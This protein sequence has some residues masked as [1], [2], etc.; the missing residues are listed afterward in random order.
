[1]KSERESPLDSE[2]G[3]F[4]EILR[5]SDTTEA[6]VI[7]G[8]HAAGFWSR[9]FLSRGVTELAEFLPFRSEDLKN[10]I[11]GPTHS[12]NSFPSE[13]P[14]HSASILNP[15][16]HNPQKTAFFGLA[17]ANPSASFRPLNQFSVS[18]R[19]F[20]PMIDFTTVKNLAT[21]FT[22]AGAQKAHIDRLVFELGRLEKDV[23][24]LDSKLADK[25]FTISELRLEIE[26]KSATIADLEEKLNDRDSV[27]DNLKGPTHEVLKL[28][29]KVSEGLDIG[30]IRSHLNMEA[31]VA[32][33]HVGVLVE[34]K[35]I[36]FKKRV[37]NF[38][39]AS[40]NF[41]YIHQKG[42][43]YVMKTENQESR[44]TPKLL[45]T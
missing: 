38:A 43:E 41:F 15:I 2:I 26:K 39:G 6:P 13:N 23:A 3:D 28:L 32:E 33:F 11:T 8:R 22:V 4:A 31:G 27:G 21:K 1:M 30:S 12:L 5:S 29:F 10:S 40:T 19:N 17:G 45:A 44:T 16:I 25:D 18:Q 36:G 37:L 9:Y 24:S 34:G 20:R 14:T 35:F 42:R 7:V